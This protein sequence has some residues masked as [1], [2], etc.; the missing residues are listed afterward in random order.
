MQQETKYAIIVACFFLLSLLAAFILFALLQS[1][2]MV[3]QAS[4]RLGGAVAGFVVV[5]TLLF[6]SYSRLIN[7]P[8][9]TLAK[10]AA[11]AITK[12]RGFKEYFSTERG[13]QIYYPKD[14][15]I[16]E[17]ALPPVMFRDAKGENV[18]IQAVK[19]HKKE[20]ADLEKNPSEFIKLYKGTLEAIYPNIKWID[21]EIYSLLGKQCPRLVY[22]RLINDKLFRQIQVAY[23]DLENERIH[24]L[25]LSCNI[26]NFDNMKPIFEKMLSTFKPA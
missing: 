1:Y 26:D 18:V 12:P 8:A 7:K 6:T 21:E 13:F 5:F 23:P 11:K 3:E 17:E 20:L 19:S 25:T 2:A 16:A 15:K 9:S 22:E 14:F 24:W 10:D 4:Y